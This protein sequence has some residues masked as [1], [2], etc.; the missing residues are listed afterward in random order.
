MASETRLHTDRCDPGEVDESALDTRILH[1]LLKPLQGWEKDLEETQAVLFEGK[2]T[3]VPGNLVLLRKAVIA[4]RNG[5][6]ASGLE[7]WEKTDEYKG[8]VQGLAAN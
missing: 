2:K 3:L 1:R 5:K 4:Q 6:L 8:L 7:G